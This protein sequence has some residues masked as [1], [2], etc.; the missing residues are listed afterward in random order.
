MTDTTRFTTLA[1]RHHDLSP[2][3]CADLARA[4]AELVDVTALERAGA[5]SFE[6]LWRD[7]HSEGWLNTWWEPRDTGFHDHGGSCVGVHVLEGRA[8]NEALAVSG[9]R[10]VREYEAGASY[11]LPG[12]G[13]HRMEHDPGAVTIH[14]YAPPIREVG[15][16]EIEDGELRR[17]PGPPDEGSPPS[18]ALSA[19]LGSP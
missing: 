10:R 12:T 15:H 14:V 1:A 7:E 11:S 4:A 3:E 18:P 8:R 6:L 16:Y 2:E 9:P 19:A 17:Q 13:I 5:G